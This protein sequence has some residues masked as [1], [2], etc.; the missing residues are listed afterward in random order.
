MNLATGAVQR[1]LASSEVNES[2]SVTIFDLFHKR[3]HKR[4]GIYS[5]C[6]C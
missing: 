4:S 1:Y 3:C 6:L 5:G 2:N